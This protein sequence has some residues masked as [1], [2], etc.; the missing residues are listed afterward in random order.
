[1]F[2]YMGFKQS[3]VWA[4]YKK[5]S[6]N[7]YTAFIASLDSQFSQIFRFNATLSIISIHNTRPQ[8]VYSSCFYT[9]FR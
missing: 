5:I 2:T 4:A 6:V 7:S 8:G 1:M 9:L 3:D